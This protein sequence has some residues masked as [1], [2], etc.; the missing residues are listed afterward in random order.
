[1]SERWPGSLISPTAP[2]PTGGGAGDTAYGVWTLEQADPYIAAG[3]WPGLGTPDPQFQYVT[4]LLHGDG[5]NAAQNNTFLDSSSN[6]FTITRNGNTTQGSFSPYGSL[7]S[8]YFNGSNDYLSLSSNA[9]FAP[10]TS[11]FTIEAWLYP[12]SSM[13]SNYVGVFVVNAT[14]GLF[15]GNLTTG[16]GLRA[17]NTGDIIY[18]PT[19][20]ANQWTHVAISRSGTSIKMFYNGQ[21]VASTTDSTNYAQGAATIAKDTGPDYFPGYISNFRLVKERQYIQHLLPQSQHHL[22]QLPIQAF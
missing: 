14:N 6:N 11:D 4:A 2:T 3:T 8:N 13:G 15:F 7:W 16:F 21:Q 10:G 22:Q 5:T 17:T 1:M 20:A 19:L 12:T 18:A 9:A